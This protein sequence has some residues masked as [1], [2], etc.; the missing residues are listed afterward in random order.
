MELKEARKLISEQLK[1]FI[2]EYCKTN[3]GLGDLYNVL[4]MEYNIELS[5]EE[6][7]A[8]K[9]LI[10]DEPSPTK[11]ETSDDQSRTYHHPLRP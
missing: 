1:N 3:W 5:Q 7:E 6:R 10:W 11:K 2:E 8:I 9:T 4:H